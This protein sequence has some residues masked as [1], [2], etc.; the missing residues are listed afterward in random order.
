M[1]LLEN[2]PVGERIVLLLT[3]VVT[4][5]CDVLCDVCRRE[6]LPASAWNLE[7]VSASEDRF[8]VFKG[9]ATG[10]SARI[11]STNQ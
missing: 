9:S 2:S 6:K 3:A 8:I 5:R 4:G 1:D 7:L 11:V 10:L